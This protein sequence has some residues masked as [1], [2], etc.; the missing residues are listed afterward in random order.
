MARPLQVYLEERDLERLEVWARER[1]W[2]KSQ[3]I[4]VAVRAL[5]RPVAK[6]P[7]LELSGDIDGLPADLS[8]NFKRYLNETYV[9]E[10]RAPY[11]ARRRRSPPTVRR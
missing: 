11:R 5:T 9:A 3:A 7:V 1:G 2:T 10:P 6:D 4:R 8:A